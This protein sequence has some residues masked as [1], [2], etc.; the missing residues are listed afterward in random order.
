MMR[1]ALAV[2]VTVALLGDASPA[3][4]QGQ[5]NK[6][7]QILAEMMAQLNRRV[8]SLEELVSRNGCCAKPD[9]R[10]HRRMDAH[11]RKP[12]QPDRA[13]SSRHL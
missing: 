13:R 8:P 7:P 4:A 6:A 1:V 9:Q 10:H 5:D 11:A 2:A 3:V 12:D